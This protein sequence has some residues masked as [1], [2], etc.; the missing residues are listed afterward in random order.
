MNKLIINAIIAS[1]ALLIFIPVTGLSQ[2]KKVKVKTVKV[3]DG[4]K[5]V[6]DTVY[7]VKDD[8]DEKE[9]L[10]TFTWVSEDD[11]L[12]VMTID[13][14]VEAEVDNDGH[15]KVV[16]FKSSNDGNVTMNHNSETSKYVIKVDEDEDGEH[17]VYIFDGD[18]DFH[19]VDMDELHDE[20][21]EHREHL[22]N[23]KIELD[24]EKIIMLEE[25]EELKE[26]KELELLVEL[27]EFEN[28]NVVIPEIPEFHG[29][30]DF[31][32]HNY[33]GDDFVTDEEL[34]DA[35]IKNKTDRLDVEDFNINNRDGVI[36]FDFKLKTEGAPK[37]IVFNYF[38]DKVF[39]GKP[40]MMNGKYVIKIDL[41]TKQYGTYFLQVIQKDSSFT[42]KIRL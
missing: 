2:E 7:T 24:G 9:I 14:D 41:S 29:D 38:G 36:D 42:K 12:G 25:L 6:L 17:K 30:H 8:E 13:V 3:V 33:H 5:V 32:I 23:I 37:I 35:G 27:D 28:I 10:K 31:F 15:K 21:E 4:E 1:L 11:S 19:G 16:V 40:E 39:T 18:G 26:L 34:R 20:L 22:K